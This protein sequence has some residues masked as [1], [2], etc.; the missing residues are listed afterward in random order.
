MVSL[1]CINVGLNTLFKVAAN[2]G[3][4]RH[5]FIVYAYAVAALILLPAPFFSRRSGTLPSLNL[6]ILVKFFVLGVIGYSSQLMGFTGINYGSPTLASAISNLSPAFTFVL[7]VIFRMEKLVVSSSRTW[8][9]V[10]GAVVSISGAFVVTFYKGPIIINADA[11]LSTPLSLYPVFD[12]PRSDWILEYPSGL[13]IMFFYSSSVSLLAALVGIFVEPDSTIWIIKP[14]IALVSIVCSGVLNGCISNS[15]D[16]W[17]L[18]MRG[19]VYVAMFKPLQIAIAA[20]M[21]VII[22][23]D[24]LYL[25]S[26][27]GAIII[28]T[29]FYTVMWGKAKEE[30]GDFV[31]ETGDLEWSTT[32][33]THPFLQTPKYNDLKITSPKSGAEKIELTNE[34]DEEIIKSEV[35]GKIPSC[36]LYGLLGKNFKDR[37]GHVGVAELSGLVGSSN[38]VDHGV[39][40]SLT[41]EFVRVYRM[42]PLL[43]D[44]LRLRNIHASP[45]PNKSPPLDTE[46]DMVELIG[47]K[48]TENLSKIGL[49]KQI[50]SMCHQACGALELW[51]YPIFLRNLV[52]HNVDGTDRPG[53]VEVSPSN[54]G[55]TLYRDRERNVAR[56]NDFRRGLLMIP[57]TKWEELTG[58]EEA[59][60][61]LRQVYNDD[62][63]ELDLLVGLLAEKKIKGFAISETAFFIFL[64]MA[65]RR[66]EADRFFT[67]DFNE[68]TCT[69][70]RGWNG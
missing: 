57:I 68:E 65:T 41:E 28:V 25:G 21:G 43:P 60:E 36:S 69:R 16:S 42:H 37:F 6:S 18:H 56:Y 66:L 29:G 27:I 62:V 30:V 45:G 7:A 49:R 3:M 1:Q 54:F 22:L 12:S 59:I 53:P 51:N 39:P 63:E 35:E 31:T 17:L 10:V 34:Q 48:G 55:F 26:M 46:I 2:G 20:A 5:V 23:G 67:S 40:Y 61:T 32:D 58:E 44:K 14:D 50:V 13:T 52:A 64:I 8:A 38:P 24:T 33:Q 70:R 19:P 4:S 9:K 47:K 11:P 15:V